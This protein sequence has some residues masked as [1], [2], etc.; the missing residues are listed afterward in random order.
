M[1]PLGLLTA[2]VSVIRVCGSP[3]LRAF[4]GRAQESSGLAE[5]EVLSCTSKTTGELFNANGG[6]ARVFG[7]PQVLEV[8]VTESNDPGKPKFKVRTLPNAED[9]WIKVSSGRGDT[10]SE[11]QAPTEGDLEALEDQTSRGSPNPSLNLGSEYGDTDSETQALIEGGQTSRRSPNLSLNLG[12]V[13]ISPVVTYLA[14]AFGMAVQTGVLIFAILTTHPKF[15][16][17]FKEP[18][19][20]GPPPSYG[21]PFTLI[22]TILV[23]TGMFF[24]AYIIEQST[25]E[26]VYTRSREK[27][28]A[29]YWVQPGNQK[30]GDQVFESFIRESNEHESLSKYIISTRSPPKSS[31]PVQL[32]IALFCSLVGFILQ[33][34]GLRALHSSVIFA[35][36]GATLLMSIIRAMLRMKRTDDGSNI[37]LSKEK[38]DQGQAAPKPGGTG[39]SSPEVSPPEASL[40]KPSL[41]RLLL[42]KLSLAKAPPPEPGTTQSETTETETASSGATETGT[43]EPDMIEPWKKRPET[44]HG[45]ELDLLAMK[46]CKVDMIFLGAA[47]GGKV[48]FGPEPESEPKPESESESESESGLEWSYPWSRPQTPQRERLEPDSKPESKLG[49]E[50]TKPDSLKSGEMPPKEPLEDAS[51]DESLND[52]SLEESLDDALLDVRRRLAHLAK[53]PDFESRKFA[54]SLKSVLDGSLEL[55]APLIKNLAGKSHYFLPLSSRYITFGSSRE[56]K[57][58]NVKIRLTTTEGGSWQVEKEELEALVGLWTLSVHRGNHH[59]LQESSTGLSGFHKETVRFLRTLEVG[60]DGID[61]SSAERWCSI[62]VTRRSKITQRF[63]SLPD[64]N[65]CRPKWHYGNNMDGTHIFGYPGKQSNSPSGLVPSDEERADLWSPEPC[66]VVKIGNNDMFGGS[67]VQLCAQ[68]I[69]CF[70]LEALVQTID[71]IDIGG[72]TQVRPI[73]SQEDTV[74]L[75]N[76]AVEAMADLFQSSGLGTKEDAYMCIF[77]A[78]YRAGKMPSSDGILSTAID[79]AEAYRKQGKWSKAFEILE[80]LCYD[81]GKPVPYETAIAQLGKGPCAEISLGELCHAAIRGT[82]KDIVRLGFEGI[83]RMLRSDVDKKFSRQYGEIG[84]QVYEDRGDLESMGFRR[85]LEDACTGLESFVEKHY[86]FENPTSERLGVWAMQ[87]DVGVFRYLLEHRGNLVATMLNDPDRFNGNTA[88]FEAVSRGHIEVAHVLLQAGARIGIRN[89]SGGS[90]SLIAARRG[91]SRILD[92]LIQHD[93]NAVRATSID[94]RDEHSLLMAAVQGR[95]VACVRG[96]LEILPLSINHRSLSGDNA[97]CVACQTYSEKKR[98]SAALDD[99]V[100]ILLDYGA[101]VR[102]ENEKGQNAL[103]IAASRGLLSA[104]ICILHAG[105]AIKI[106]APDGEGNTALHLAAKNCHYEIMKTLIEEKADPNITNKDENTALTITVKNE[107]PWQEDEHT[108]ADSGRNLAVFRNT[109]LDSENITRALVESVWMLIH[110]HGKPSFGRSL[111][112]FDSLLAV[113]LDREGPGSLWKYLRAILERLDYPAVLER[114]ANR[115]TWE[116]IAHYQD[117]EK[118]LPVALEA[119]DEG[120]TTMLSVNRHGYVVYYNTHDN[121]G[122]TAL[123]CAVRLRLS[124]LVEKL[125][126]MGATPNC[127]E[128]APCPLEAAVKKGDFEISQLLLE[129]YPTDSL[130]HVEK[131]STL[132]HWVVDQT[133]PDVLMMEL[134]LKHGAQASI[135]IFVEDHVTPLTLAISSLCQVTR[136]VFTIIR[137]GSPVICLLDKGA[138]VTGIDYHLIDKRAGVTGIGYHLFTSGKRDN[139]ALP[140]ASGLETR[141]NR[142]LGDLV[143][144]MIKSVHMAKDIDHANTPGPGRELK[145]ILIMDENIERFKTI[146]RYML[147]TWKKENPEKERGDAKWELGGAAVWREGGIWEDYED[148]NHGSFRISRHDSGDDVEYEIQ[149]GAYY[150]RRK[151]RTSLVGTSRTRAHIVP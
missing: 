58:S 52:T 14:A 44:L 55:M 109:R 45:H 4:I 84:L 96:V 59:E 53:W 99:I 102:S 86:S 67:L 106:D 93:P 27:P 78:L 94:G 1:A 50:Q 23:C 143:D 133:F 34:V 135:N 47:N 42:S 117:P 147:A 111:E 91:D 2:V 16:D 37:I 121:H 89:K 107:Y 51:I 24:C 63:K 76:T 120:S 92:M 10:K 60:N 150:R 137:R 38:Q 71:N 6:I 118:G 101:D 149:E 19:E 108:T 87:G 134:L 151:T 75:Q 40:S 130:H 112:V 28:S 56:Q 132:L 80:W 115:V 100:G 79:S 35:Q 9:S 144:N 97:L 21:L 148:I 73:V 77:P 49:V 20:G 18:E 22:G 57:T 88:I 41:F 123:H 62:W 85:H 83:G 54:S 69:F 66:L 142:P 116:D 68:D 104:A 74:L 29:V 139:L 126:E 25:D 128:D 114:L 146:M 98:R 125:L 31:H 129:R 136:S 7:S 122:S 12:I 103:H 39:Q 46:I 81:R 61:S 127:R 30:I 70:L 113:S 90:P 15:I 36:L 5:I 145:E 32:A 82:D 124:E 72:T 131:H 3:T 48:I 33:F 11:A 141:D 43:I 105:I 110:T 138:R 13:K 140:L 26:V 17:R 8:V 95:S 119:A 64:A 65:L